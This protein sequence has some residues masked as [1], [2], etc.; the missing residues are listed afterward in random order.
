[1]FIGSKKYSKK[2]KPT[3]S[4]F[5][6]YLINTLENKPQSDNINNSFVLSSNNILK[7]IKPFNNP[8]KKLLLEKLDTSKIKRIEQIKNLFVKVVLLIMIIPKIY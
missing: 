5:N 4:D 3:I 2:K 6:K 1:M 8:N 7:S